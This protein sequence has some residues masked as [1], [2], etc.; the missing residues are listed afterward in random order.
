MH[1]NLLFCYEVTRETMG[2]KT[3]IDHILTNV[4]QP[5]TVITDYK[6]QEITLKKK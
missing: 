2:T 4:M 3:L 1:S 5:K 6:I